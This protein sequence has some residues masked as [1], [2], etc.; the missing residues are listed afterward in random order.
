M[1]A[2]DLTAVAVVL[3][4]VLFKRMQPPH[5]GGSIEGEFV[6]DYPAINA[7]PWA[8]DVTPVPSDNWSG[9]VYTAADVQGVPVEGDNQIPTVV[10]SVL[11]L[12]FGAAFQNASTDAGSASAE[13]N[14]RA[15][16]DMIAFSEGTTGPDGYRFMFG[17][18]K[19]PDRLCA[20]LADHPRL[21]F[22]FTVAG[23]ELKT[24]AAG[25]YQ[26]LISTWDELRAKLHL[27]DFGPASQ[28]AAAIELIRQRGALPDVR[29]G[30]VSAAISKC[31]KT[32]ASL[33][34]AGYGQP[35]QKIASLLN[36]YK[37]AGGSTLTA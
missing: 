29:A 7:D 1:N 12:D 21:Y 17:Y 30:R 23:R 32:W 3:G 15:F 11:N 5:A 26:F 19:N 16:L 35:E 37:S 36:A 10:D 6:Q 33:P 18:P 27:P 24:S 22:S 34:G 2:Y 28:D 4:F 8:V 9:N 14:V 20:S 13:P 31:A 25:R